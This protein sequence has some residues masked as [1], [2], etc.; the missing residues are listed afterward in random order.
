MPRSLRIP[1]RHGEALVVPPL[2]EWRSVIEGTQRAAAG[3]SVP[4]AGV[5]LTERRRQARA[6]ALAAATSACQRLGIPYRE[7]P[8]VPGAIVMTGHQ[9]QLF[10]P[11]VWAKHFAADRYA[12][13]SGAVAIDLVVDSDRV[14]RLVLRTPCR[15]DPSAGREIVLHSGGREECYACAPPPSAEQL[16]RFAAAVEACASEIADPDVG[17]RT[18]RFIVVLKEAARHTSSLAEAMVV[19]RRAFE[20]PAGTEYLELFLTEQCASETFLAFAAQVIADARR[21]ADIFNEEVLRYRARTKTRSSAH[22]F[23]E[24]AAEGGAVETPFWVIAGA[25]RARTW[26]EPA[27]GRLAIEG[28]GAAEAGSDPAE[29]ASRL[30][31]EGLRIVPKAA[32][33][34]MFQR[35]FV[36]D[37]FIHGVGGS[38]Y[39]AVTDAVIERWL[40]ISPPAYAVVSVTMRLPTVAGAAEEERAVWLRRRLREAEHNPDRLLS[41]ATFDDE[42]ERLAAEALA[43]EKRGLLE[44]YADPAADK[45]ALNAAV[46]D[47]NERLRASLRPLIASMEA[48]FAELDSLQSEVAALG[49]REVS[50]PFFDP[51]EVAKVMR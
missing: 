38:R 51:C 43:A 13:A 1:H 25:R 17:S 44:R 49:D 2:D 40:G 28:A 31:A 39:E 26:Y 8:G 22:P 36:A 15:R 7:P 12:K 27:S 37:L 35:L 47:V 5:P 10:H 45:K 32:T 16:E 46:Q 21:F 34:T 29:I 11:G 14:G 23:P 33:L 24:L 18:Q 30:E 50:F 3:W 19:A 4:I 48:E 20:A 9:P 41:E 42:G 6:E